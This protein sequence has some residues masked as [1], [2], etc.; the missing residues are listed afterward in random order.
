MKTKEELLAEN[1][2]CENIGPEYNQTNKLDEP[3]QNHINL[4]VSAMFLL[5]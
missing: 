5:I 2:N 4:R 1:E 3:E